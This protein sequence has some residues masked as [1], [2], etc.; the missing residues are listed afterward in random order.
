MNRR[1]VNTAAGSSK[2]KNEDETDAPITTTNAQKGIP[3]P[4]QKR[5]RKVRPRQQASGVVE[6][7]SVVLL[8]V[9]LGIAVVKAFWI[10]FHWA[11]DYQQQQQQQQPQGAPAAAA[12]TTTTTTTTTTVATTP[13]KSDALPKFPVI[14]RQS[15]IE[16]SQEAIDMCTQAL[17]HTL[18]TTTVVLPNRETFVHTG[19]IDD[20]WLRDS[21]AQV[22]TLLIPASPHDNK[23]LIASDPQLDRIVAGLIR[24]SAMYI[25]HDPYA[26][27][28]RIDDTYVFSQAQK[29]LGRHDLISTWNYELDSACYYIRMLWM[30]WKQ[31]PNGDSSDSVLRLPQVVEAVEIM[32]T[33]WKAEQR[34]EADEFPK[35][36]LLDCQN[37]GKPY[38]YPSLKRNGKGTPTNATSGLTWTG[39]RPSDDEC[40]YH[41]LVPANMFA[42]VALGYVVE[43]A[44]AEVWQN[45][46]LAD[47]AAKLAQE[48]Q[49]GLDDHAIVNHPK[50]GKIYA[51][52]VDGL[53]NSNLMDDA[54]V[55]SL[56]SIPYLGYNYNPE[57][58]QNTRRFI[59]SPDNPTYQ[60]GSNAI[61]GP[62]EG[63]GSPHMQARIRKNIWPMSI[64][65]QGLV[66]EDAHER[67][68]LVEL[69]VKASAGTHWMHESINVQNPKDYTRPWFCWA[70]A[71]FAELVLTLTDKCPDPNHKYRV[72][73][74]RD[75][76]LVP[77]GPF[78]DS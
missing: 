38:T 55:P 37:C 77:G 71:L 73:E 25:R 40:E 23:A 42:V 41:F 3:D 32:V 74:W 20:L 57:I 5:R 16:L 53:G 31:S 11:V 14:D 1:V 66:T 12:D 24:R 27:A 9:V 58:Y 60:K 26:N 30:Y 51:Y 28:F 33:L 68:R 22:H 8:F 64:A 50:Y 70:D 65:M 39:F 15:G 75:P 13:K 7:I 59:F 48:I 69:L 54:N 10:G 72:M 47:R 62:I 52:E 49:R 63:Y 29:K 34:H 6:T 76:Q 78:A 56:L 18:E 46:S 17:W 43:L 21:A 4:K 45:P 19:D 67:A 2:K 61:T 35:G 36:P 44:T